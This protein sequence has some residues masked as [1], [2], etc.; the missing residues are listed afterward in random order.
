MNPP[1]MFAAGAVVT[2]AVVVIAIWMPAAAGSD[3]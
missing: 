3:A 1:A 2:I